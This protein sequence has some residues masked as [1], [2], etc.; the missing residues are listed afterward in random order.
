[1]EPRRL[2]RTLQ[3]K[4]YYYNDDTPMYPEMPPSTEF[5]KRVAM[6]NEETFDSSQYGR[7]DDIVVY[8]LFASKNHPNGRLAF[9]PH[10]SFM[11]V[12]ED[13]LLV[14]EPRFTREMALDI[15]RIYRGRVPERSL[16]DVE[17]IDRVCEEIQTKYGEILTEND[18]P[19]LKQYVAAANPIPNPSND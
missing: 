15:C 6:L 5:E 2:L 18:L 1:M 7:V 12:S 13:T 3:H 9:K 14:S 11:E 19:V 17:I 16:A 4:V 10:T 8:S